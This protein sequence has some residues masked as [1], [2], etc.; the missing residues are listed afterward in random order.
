MDEWGQVYLLNLLLRY[1]RTMLPKPTVSQHSESM[2]EEVDADLQLLL[3][4]SEPLFQSRNPAVRLPFIP[5][6]IL[7]VHISLGSA[8]CGARLLLYR[9]SVI[10][11]QN[12]EPLASHYACIARSRACG[13]CVSIDYHPCTSGEYSYLTLGHNSSFLDSNCSQCNTSDFYYAPTTL[14]K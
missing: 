3:V 7:Q 1:A 5:T 11:K 6:A 13:P 8:G 2:E 10:Y 12:C 9:P 4:S 14:C